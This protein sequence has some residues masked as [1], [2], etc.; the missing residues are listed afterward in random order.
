MAQGR[1]HRLWNH[2]ERASHLVW[3]LT[4]CEALGR[5]LCLS[6]PSSL[7]HS[8]RQQQLAFRDVCSEQYCW[9]EV[10]RSLEAGLLPPEASL[11]A[12]GGF[13]Q[14]LWARHPIPS[15]C[16]S[17]GGGRISWSSRDGRFGFG[18]GWKTG[19]VPRQDI[20]VPVGEGDGAP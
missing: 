3:S 19:E 1:E 15:T 8:M 5:S 10:F 12:A 18:V 17:R 14:W 9:I 13:Q 6:D 11:V 20:P 4:G 7:F 2:M 16:V